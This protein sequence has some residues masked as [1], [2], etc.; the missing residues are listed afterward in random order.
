[1][2]EQFKAN[3]PNAVFSVVTPGTFAGLGIPLR[4]GRAFDARDA[5]D[6]PLTA[7]INETLARR[8]FLGQ[9]P[10]GRSI[11]CGLDTDKPMRIVGIVGD[12]R[13][14]GAEQ[15]A[16][17]EIYMPYDQHTR[18][19]GTSLSVVVR[20]TLAPGALAKTLRREVHERSPDVPVKFS[21]LEDHVAQNRATPRFRTLLLVIFAAIALCLAMAGVYGVLAYMVSQ[22][23]KSVY[24]WRWARAPGASC[25]WF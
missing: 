23:T 11:F 6:A 25:G 17:P 4:A 1:L 9:N 19:A 21:T 16:E 18:S 24:A 5:Y 2:P 10:I 12:V 22:R 8:S 15:R 7:I 3:A 14:H 13:E 20:T